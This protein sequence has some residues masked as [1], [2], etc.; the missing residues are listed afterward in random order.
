MVTIRNGSTS[1]LKVE[2]SPRFT[3]LVFVFSLTTYALCL[4]FQSL[5]LRCVLLMVWHLIAIKSW[6]QLCP[7]TS[8]T[9]LNK[10]NIRIYRQAV[11]ADKYATTHFSWV[12]RGDWEG[13]FLYNSLAKNVCSVYFFIYWPLA[14][15]QKCPP[16]KQVEYPAIYSTKMDS[17]H[18][19]SS[20]NIK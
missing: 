20:A 6:T 5:P 8:C 3:P 14:L 19:K 17:S 11:S 13:L 15:L 4:R 12:T 10:K 7:Q 1:E 16:A 2:A 9:K 18:I